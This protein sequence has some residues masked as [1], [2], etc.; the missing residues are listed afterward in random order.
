M[1]GC[2]IVLVTCPTQRNAGQ[3][4]SLVVDKRL[5][6]CVNILPRIQSVFRWKG[7]VDR[8]DEVLLLIK[9]TSKR[10][11]ALLRAVRATHPYD[12]PEII[13]LPVTDGHRPYLAWVRDS[14]A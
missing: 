14:V 11:P 1:T 2:L 6:A 12:V 10:F 13:A 3:L 7:K 9:T 8:A 4:A 5:A